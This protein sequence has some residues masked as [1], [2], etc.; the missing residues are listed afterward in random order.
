MEVLHAR[1]AGIDVHK[2][3]VK[4]CVRL[5]EDGG[6]ARKEVRDYGTITAELLRLWEW[7]ESERDTRVP[8]SS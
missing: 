3:Q 2:Q 8:T 1:C 7:L 5:V 6:R 4:I